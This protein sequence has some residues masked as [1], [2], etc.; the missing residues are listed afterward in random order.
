MNTRILFLILFILAIPAAQAL[1]G[2]ETIALLGDSQ[3]WIGGDNCEKETG[4]SHHLKTAF[5]T[6]KIDTYARSG[7]TWTNTPQT[8]GDTE[9][10]Y[11]V[12]N[13]ENVIY[14]QAL[15]L[16]KAVQRGQKPVPDIIVLFAGGNDAMFPRRRPGMF[17]EKKLPS[18]SV[19]NLKPSQFT[20]LASSIELTCRLLKESFPKARLVLVTPTH[21]SKATPESVKNVSITIEKTC[22]KLSMPVLRADLNDGISHEIEKIKPHKFTYDGIH[23]N[24]AGARLLAEYIIKNL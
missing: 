20:T 11:A 9:A 5:P 3:T 22:K 8:K 6:C 21:M 1:T 10:Y 2:K 18:G 23:T 17:N 4:W 16:I 24:P 12:L 19:K 13:N 14:N 7:A 15:R